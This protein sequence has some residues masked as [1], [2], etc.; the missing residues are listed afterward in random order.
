GWPSLL[1][2]L[3]ASDP[4]LGQWWY[5]PQTQHRLAQ[6]ILELRGDRENFRVLCLGAP[7][8]VPPLVAAGCEV[9]LVDADPDVLDAVRSVCNANIFHCDLLNAQLDA[10]PCHA[11]LVDPP[12]Y[13]DEMTSFLRHA[14][15]H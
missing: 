10:A 8:V 11:A 14:S 12:W 13:Q 9:D 3:P 2:R 7:T 5:T 1:E 4:A 15:R 6:R